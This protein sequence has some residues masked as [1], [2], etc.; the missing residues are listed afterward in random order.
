MVIGVG[1]DWRRD[2]AAGLAVVRML[3]ERPCPGLRLVELH[4][5]PAALLDRWEGEERVVLVDAVSSGAP[6]GTIH[7]LDAT[8]CALAGELHR[9]SSHHLSVAEAVELGRVLDR[10]PAAL[11][12]IGIEGSSFEAGRG[13]APQV[14]LA[15]EQVAG[16]L[17]ATLA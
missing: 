7:R 2:D 8:T 14:E 3:R 1:N 6:P 11:E 12:L 5:E 9:S 15:A 13:L 17:A 16:R 4:G 10:L